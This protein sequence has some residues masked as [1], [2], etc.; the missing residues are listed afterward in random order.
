MTKEAT[1]IID[2]TTGALTVEGFT[3]SE[4][5]ELTFDLLAQ[6]ERVNCARPINAPPL[7]SPPHRITVMDAE[8]ILRVYR[9]YHH[10]VIDGPGR[11]SVVQTAGCTLRCPGCYVPE[12]HDPESGVALRISEAVELALDPRGEPRDGVTVLG[13]EPFLQ[14]QA[15]A[16]LLRALKDRNQ[17]ITLYSGYTL[18]QLQSRQERMID[19][20]LAFADILIDGAFVAALAKGA[21]EWRGSTNQRIIYNPSR[22]AR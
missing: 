19:E 14:P 10:S 20:C 5:R 1:W 7:T 8:P 9:V 17:H 12:T 15:L 16:A 6:A 21:G 4:A 22:G 18:E 2:R 13:G 11:R 3:E